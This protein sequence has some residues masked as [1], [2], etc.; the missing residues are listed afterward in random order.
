MNSK[1]VADSLYN[2]TALKQ[3]VNL[4]R[5]YNYSA[6]ATSLPNNAHTSLSIT[7]FTGLRFGGYS[8]DLQLHNYKYSTRKPADLRIVCIQPCRN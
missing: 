3:R 7:L 5:Q 4:T 2:Y 8:D 1:A 6:I